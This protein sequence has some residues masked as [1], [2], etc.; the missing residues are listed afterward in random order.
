M[1]GTELHDS[2]GWHSC[3]G[4]KHYSDLPNVSGICLRGGRGKVLGSRY[5]EQSDGS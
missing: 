3:G 5:N 1:P 2:R 4:G